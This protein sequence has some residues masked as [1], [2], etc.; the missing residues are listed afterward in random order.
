MTGKRGP[1]PDTGQPGVGA[2]WRGGGVQMPTGGLRD[3]ETAGLPSGG[4]LWV[5]P[6]SRLW[7]TDVSNGVGWV[8]RS[9]Q[10]P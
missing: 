7:T 4:S 8:W 5:Y 10:T 9:Q 2:R 1:D 6:H 3:R